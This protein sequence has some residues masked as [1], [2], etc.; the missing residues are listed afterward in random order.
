M[1]AK[2]MGQVWELDLPH[3]EQ[4]VMLALADH[5]EDDGSQI[6]PSVDRLAWKTGYKTRQVQNILRA[7]E[8]RGLI[9]K[10]A[11][12]LGGRGHATEYKMNIEKGA[13]KTPFI[14]K[15]AII[16]DTER[17]QNPAQRVQ[18]VTQKGAKSSTKGAIAIAPQP[19]Y[20]H[21][22]KHQEPSGD[23]A[24]NAAPPAADEPVDEVRHPS[25][26]K[27][28]PPSKPRPKTETPKEPTAQQEMVGALADV[29]GMD[30]RLNGSRLGKVAV[31]L[32]RVGATP[33]DL[34]RYYGPGGWWY[35]ADWRGQK[36]EFPR[37]EQ[38]LETWGQWARATP[39]VNGHARAAPTSKTNRNKALLDQAM[40]ETMGDE[41]PPG[42]IDMP[43]RRSSGY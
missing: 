5:G 15:G 18:S 22:E 8:S 3:G 19:S 24:A 38:V 16:T 1:S 42:V 37:P 6:F 12:P 26:P 23:S 30:T 21:Q 4:L 28:S 20:N 33:D 39:Q 17:V 34:R 32:S 7:L 43:P 40:R 14:K 29:T 35:K 2:L 31:Q 10:V 13:K 27:P 36:G 11:Y 25:K 41:L 9:E